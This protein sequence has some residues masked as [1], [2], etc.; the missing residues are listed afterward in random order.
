VFG[1]RRG[2]LLDR[3]RHVAD[4]AAGRLRQSKEEKCPSP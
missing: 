4:V 3:D 2:V 1:C